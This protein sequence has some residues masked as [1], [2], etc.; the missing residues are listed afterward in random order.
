MDTSLQVWLGNVPAG[1]SPSDVKAEIA[2]HGYGYPHFAK[3]LKSKHVGQKLMN[4][5]VTMPSA[6]AANELLHGY[7]TWSNGK[8]AVIRAA[9]ADKKPTKGESADEAGVRW[10]RDQL[11]RQLA[12]IDATPPSSHTPASSSS[13]DKDSFGPWYGAPDNDKDVGPMLKEEIGM[14]KKAMAVPIVAKEEELE[15]DSQQDCHNVAQPVPHAPT[16]KRSMEVASTDLGLKDPRH[17]K[18][19]PTQRPRS[20]L[21]FK[22]PRLTVTKC[23]RSSWDRRNWDEL[24]PV[25]LPATEDDV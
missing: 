14:L 15:E 17:H 3:V 7:V 2:S 18:A 25:S 6:E 16:R 24:S 10:K 23:A 4:C 21:R 20:P 13:G 5:I 11:V 22:G 1:T 12:Q 19:A 8:H 9:F